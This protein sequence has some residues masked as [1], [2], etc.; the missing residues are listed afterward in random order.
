VNVSIIKNFTAEQLD[1]LV[2]A[3]SFLM[4]Y[5]IDKMCI[6]GK[7]ET[8]LTIIDLAN[9]SMTS[10]PVTALRKFISSSQTNFRGRAYKNFILNAN[11]I[12]RGSFGLFKSMMDEFS[13]QKINMLGSNYK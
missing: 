10:I 5:H 13:A 3:V 2:P 9:V 11:I 8:I 6:P 1:S 12:I 7:S 4:T